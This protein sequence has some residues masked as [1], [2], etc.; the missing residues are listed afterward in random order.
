[1]KS[2]EKT[3]QRLIKERCSLYISKSEL[4]KFLNH[5][6]IS[7]ASGPTK[8]QVLIE[9]EKRLHEFVHFTFQFSTMP[10]A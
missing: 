3:L 2:N 6:Y 9:D 10:S 1:M 4:S 7:G 8:I 5:Y